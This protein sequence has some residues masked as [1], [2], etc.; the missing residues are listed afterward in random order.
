[1]MRT[2]S[3]RSTVLATPAAAIGAGLTIR[4]A[5]LLGIGLTVGIWLVAGYYSAGRIATFE[6]D[7]AAISARYIRAQ[8]LLTTARSQLLLAS[9]SVR[10]ALLD[11]DPSKASDYRRQLDD[12]YDLAEQALQQYVPVLDSTPEPERI[13]HLRREIDDFKSATQQALA[14]DQHRSPAAAA[15]LLREQVV[16]KRAAATQVADEL[17][18]L[19]RAAFVRTQADIASVFLATQRGMWNSLGLALVASL[20]IGLAA[21]LYAGRLERRIRQQRAKD[22]Q[23][24]IDLQ[25]LSAKLISVQEEERRTIAREL[26]DEVGQAL[27]AIKVELAIAQRG[28]DG[29][30][31]S[32]GL[33]DEARSI[34]D[35]ALH[36]VRDLSQLLHPPVLDDLG[37]PAAIESHSR[38]PRSRPTGSF[39]RR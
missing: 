15:L 33:L 1:M 5:L 34:T 13:A 20:G 19:N 26:H 2:R 30:G 27:T 8:E 11:P 17:Q 29:H 37:L 14:T 16:P 10:D 21:I 23:N 36:A 24:A 28:M 4:A 38:T 22:A 12:A 31:A 3:G 25:R 7:E 6:G 35:G 18:A 39:R 9:V 32:L